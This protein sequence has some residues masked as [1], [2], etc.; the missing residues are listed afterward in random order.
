MKKRSQ[1]KKKK[2][3]FTSIISARYNVTAKQLLS[4]CDGTVSD[5]IYSTEYTQLLLTGRR[6]ESPVGLLL[7]RHVSSVRLCVC[8]C[9]AV[10]NTRLLYCFYRKPL[11]R[12][13]I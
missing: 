3:F 8:V 4:E 1:Q 7:F 2:T 11:T 10:C 6:A 9:L 5:T 13:L 12:Q